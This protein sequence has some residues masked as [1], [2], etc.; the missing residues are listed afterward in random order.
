[1]LAEVRQAP[2][3]PGSSAF[4]WHLKPHR[5][6]RSGGFCYPELVECTCPHLMLGFTA[7]PSTSWSD[8]C[9]AHGVGTDFFRGLKVKPFGYADEQATTREEWLDWKGRDAEDQAG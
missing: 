5:G 6:L 9:P 3:V 7:L 2:E 8:M 4:P 1:M